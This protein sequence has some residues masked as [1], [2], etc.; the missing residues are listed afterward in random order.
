MVGVKRSNPNGLTILLARLNDLDGKVAK[1]GWFASS[2]YENGAPIAGI[3]AVQEYGATIN[4]PG[5]T[6][7]KIG[8]DGKAIFVSKA[9][10]ANLPVTKPHTIVIPP[11]PFM[12]PTVTRDKPTWISLFKDG[13]KAV[14]NGQ[15]TGLEVLD[16]VGQ[17]AAGGIAK[18]IVAVTAPS[19][20]ASTVAARRR[21]MADRKTVGA[22]DKPLVHSG[23]LLDTVSSAVEDDDGQSG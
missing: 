7:Y 12:R 5:G 18:S 22:L 3:A 23:L 2:K 13:A 1:A 9:V 21:Q 19:L 11:R 6:P 8:P 15:R 16:A 10:G 4:H 14:L 17:F 20:K